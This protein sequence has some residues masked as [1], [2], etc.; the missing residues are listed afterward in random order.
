MDPFAPPERL[1]VTEAFR[2]YAA[3][4]LMAALAGDGTPLRDELAHAAAAAGVR[5]AADDGWSDI[6]S[7]LLVER[8]EP[9]LGEGQATI[10][11]DYPACEAALAR[12]SPKDPK[13]ALRFELYAC[14][15]ELANAFEELTDPVEQ[16]RRFAAEMAEKARLYGEPYP[17]DEDFLRAL[18]TMPEASGAALGFDRLVL[19]AAGAST[20]EEV[21]WTPPPA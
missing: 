1:S 18:E 8:V 14:G 13:T 10:L 20:L 21:A 15:I 5:V 3:V 19:L 16:R 6:F 17:L 4:D 9:R 11:Y 12:L 7:K 2:R